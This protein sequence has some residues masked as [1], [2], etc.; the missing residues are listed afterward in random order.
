MT[1]DL[2]ARRDA[3]RAGGSQTLDHGM[4]LRRGGP[5]FDPA[6]EKT[7]LRPDPRYE[8]GGT[9]VPIGVNKKMKPE[10]S[11]VE[12]ATA[13]GM[14]RDG[15]ATLG[16]IAGYGGHIQ[17]KIAENIHSSTVQRANDLASVTRNRTPSWNQTPIADHVKAD[18]LNDRSTP[19]GPGVATS[20]D[21]SWRMQQF[22]EDGPGY[23]HC[24]TVPT[25]KSKYIDIKG[26]GIPGYQ[27]YIP[28]KVPENVY[29]SAEARTNRI[30]QDRRQI[31]AYTPVK[32][33]CGFAAQTAPAFWHQGAD[34]PTIRNSMVGGGTPYGAISSRISRRRS[35]ALAIVASCTRPWG[36]NT[37]RHH[38]FHARGS[39]GTSRKFGTRTSGKVA[40]S[41]R[42]RILRGGW[43][44]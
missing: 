8:L 7:V 31:P 21:A 9:G 6:R 32:E 26:S 10:R 30:A 36:S 16:S 22:G 5:K 11:N 27:G 43:I 20:T 24:V 25:K 1:T 42:M 44:H 15:P 38:P 17:G 13:A 12:F 19:T 33:G 41:L 3:R 28:G 4:D 29:G 23:S 14:A 2:S 39:C 40:T 37:D 18:H 34:F 35:A